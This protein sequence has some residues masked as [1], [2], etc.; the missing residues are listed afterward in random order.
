MRWRVIK[1]VVV[2]KLVAQLDDGALVN[3]R[4]HKVEREGMQYLSHIYL[5]AGLN[6]EIL[7]IE[8]L[9]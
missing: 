8:R 4:A 3:V 7:V 9:G 2:L 5:T 6:E 1:S